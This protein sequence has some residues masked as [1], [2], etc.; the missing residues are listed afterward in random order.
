MTSNLVVIDIDME[1]KNRVTNC[2]IYVRVRI[3]NFKHVRS[4]TD[5]QTPPDN[6]IGC[7]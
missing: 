7:I 3:T 1:E 2:R 5:T 6:G 4:V